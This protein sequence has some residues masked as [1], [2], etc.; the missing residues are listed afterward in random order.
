MLSNYKLVRK[1]P[2]TQVSRI[3]IRSNKFKYK[4]QSSMRTSKGIY[5]SL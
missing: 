5:L 4:M 3:D 1:I 2:N